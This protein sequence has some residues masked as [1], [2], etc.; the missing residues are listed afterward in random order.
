MSSTCSCTC[1]ELGL[2][3]GFNCATRRHQRLVA[4]LWRELGRDVADLNRERA[5]YQGMTSYSGGSSS[6]GGGYWG[7]GGGGSGGYDPF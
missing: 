1:H 5:F 3:R 7:E 6:A 4:K 2:N